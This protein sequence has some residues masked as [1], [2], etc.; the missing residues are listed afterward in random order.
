MITEKSWIIISYILG[1]I[2]SGFLIGK[3]Y[4]IDVLEVGW[5]KTSGSNVFKNVGKLAGILTALLDILK[6]YLA[7]F[8]AQKLGF[9]PLAQVFSGLA[10]VI[11]HNWSIFI[12]FSGGRGI[13]TL[14]GCLL[15]FSPKITGLSLILFSIPAI[16]WNTSIGTLCFLAFAIIFSVTFNQFQTIG[17]FTIFSLL[18]ILIKRLSPIKEIIKSKEKF[19]LFRNR[20]FFDNDEALFNLR[21]NRILKEIE[22]NK[23]LKF[24]GNTLLLP[25]K[26][27][28]KVAKFGVKLGVNAVK[29]P[30]EFIFG[31]P[32]KVV[33]EIKP[34]DLKN[35]MRAAAQKVVQYQEDINKIN[36]FPVADKD[37]GY[38][39]SATLLG[40]EGAI[41]QK[42]YNSFLELAKDIKE[43]AMINARGNA[44]MIYTGYLIG[45]LN[46]IHD[47]KTING[48]IL[49]SAMK[50]GTDSA[51][52][53]ILN[54]VE[55]TIL[56]VVRTVSRKSVEMAKGRKEKNIIKVLEESLIVGQKA[57]EETK[58]KLEVLR[59]NNVVDAGGLGFVKILEAWIESLKGEAL[60]AREDLKSS[61]RSLY[62]NSVYQETDYQT[63]IVFIIER[64]GVNLEKIKEDLAQ[65]GDSIDAL[66]LEDKIKLHIHTNSI[67]GVRQ[68]LKGLKILDWREESLV[69]EG[70]IIVAKKPLGLVVGETANLPREFLEKNQIESVPFKITFSDKESLDSENFYDKLKKAKN[71]PTTSAATFNDYFNHYKKA[72]ERFEKILVITL[73]SKLSGAYSQAK[74][75]RSIFKKP[76]KLNIFVFDCFTVE[77]AEGLIIMRAQELILAGRKIDE[78]IE[79][80]KIF[81]PKVKLIGLISDIKYLVRGGRFKMPRIFTPI[82]S[83]IQKTGVSLLFALEGGKVKLLGVRFGQNLAEILAEEV[84]SRSNNREIKTAIA[85]TGNPEASREL[86]EILEKNPK[87]KV[88]FTSFVTPVIEIHAG[89]GALITGFYPVDK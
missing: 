86:K 71:I 54:P 85:H 15:A 87:I 27:G 61:A 74:I 72:L 60:E 38:N 44:G 36:V 23:I 19:I 34:E 55:G 25:P 89:P 14:L 75:A 84:K 88:L 78:I 8:V 52:R 83:L 16:I 62:Q 53:A 70:K 40:I 22:D 5:K 46:K 26:I 81:C 58:N 10:A 7:V 6:G 35:M 39:L 32:E 63:E 3:A 69:S 43:G 13:G 28:W 9:S 59:Q 49:S 21:I 41:S 11:G 17:L 82:V 51:Y 1:S 56:D 4:G 79:E 66:E 2:P 42:E 30:I 48:S 50:K 57:L 20:I 80:L 18:P 24:L 67:E 45:F 29:K 65:L 68:V 37:T 77:V 64:E 31:T 12:R 33:T 47:L 76:E 73:P